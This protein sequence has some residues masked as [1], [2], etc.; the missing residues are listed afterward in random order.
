MNIHIIG[1]L[2]EER[3]KDVENLFEEI[4]EKFPN[5]GKE[6]DIQF[7][8]HKEFQTKWTQGCQLIFQ[9]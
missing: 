5:L 7:Q 8:K 6:V 3:E 4:T 9:Q 2:G 1:L